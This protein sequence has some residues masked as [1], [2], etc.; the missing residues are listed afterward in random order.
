VKNSQKNAT[1]PLRSRSLGR[2]GPGFAIGSNSIG[3]KGGIALILSY[4]G[5]R[6]AFGLYFVYGTRSWS[7]DCDCR[8]RRGIIGK[9]K[10][11]NC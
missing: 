11:S 7:F 9:A 6:W 4:S 10:D 3:L 8:E 5:G 2:F 1:G